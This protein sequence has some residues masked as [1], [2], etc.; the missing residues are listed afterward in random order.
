[1]SL[2]NTVAALSFAKHLFERKMT[3]EEIETLAEFGVKKGLHPTIAKY[4]YGTVILDVIE[5]TVDRGSTFSDLEHALA[6]ELVR[7]SIHGYNSSN[8]AINV[9]VV[10][11]H[12]SDTCIFFGRKMPTQ[13]AKDW[14]DQVSSCLSQLNHEHQARVR[15]ALIEEKM[16]EYR[17]KLELENPVIKDDISITQSLC[18]N[19]IN[20]KMSSAYDVFKKGDSWQNSWFRKVQ[21]EGLPLKHMLLDTTQPLPVQA[22][23]S[24]PTPEPVSEHAPGAVQEPVREP[25]QTPVYVPEFFDPVNPF[26]SDEL[27]T[28]DAM[29]LH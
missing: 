24:E 21:K 7:N 22:H 29:L 6:E 19:H 28:E 12:T 18:R 4:K 20:L 5:N 27:I 8:E 1:M 15:E 16:K 14:E 13:G 26:F 9:E 23:V 10:P 11:D 3:N 2:Y 17:E 25:V